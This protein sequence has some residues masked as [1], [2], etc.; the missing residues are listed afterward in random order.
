MT[1]EPTIIPLEGGLVVENT[2]DKASTFI[3]DAGK[4]PWAPFRTRADFKYTETAIKGL[5]GK[6]IVDAQLQG[7]NN[8]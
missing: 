7:I 8:H 3:Q 4:K 5:L 1:T 2:P 6:N